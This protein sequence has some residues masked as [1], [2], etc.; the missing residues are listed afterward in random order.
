[1]SQPNQS[2]PLWK[3]RT[4]SPRVVVRACVHVCMCVW[5][6][7]SCSSCGWTLPFWP[8]YRTVITW[9]ETSIQLLL[10]S[11]TNEVKHRQIGK[12][13][14]RQE[15]R[16]D[17]D[18]QTDILTYTKIDVSS[19]YRSC[20]FTCVFTYVD[21]GQGVRKCLC[22]R[23]HVRSCT[24]CTYL[25]VRCSSIACGRKGLTS[26]WTSLTACKQSQA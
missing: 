18:T 2:I 20:A 9:E 26:A 24:S 6:A 10:T 25:Y 19:C 12:D 11:S 23:V 5:A 13:K 22:E 4:H 16:L 15:D 21:V 3:L 8:V 1:M 14:G 17:R 7:E